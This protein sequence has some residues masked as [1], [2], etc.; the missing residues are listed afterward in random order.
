MKNKHPLGSQVKWVFVFGAEV[1]LN[2]IPELI[3]I[4]YIKKRKFSIYHQIYPQKVFA[5]FF[6]GLLTVSQKPL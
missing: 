1:R 5:A 6:D 4:I 2:K 3:E